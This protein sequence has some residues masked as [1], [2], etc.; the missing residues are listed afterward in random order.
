[1]AKLWIRVQL[2]PDGKIGP[3]KIALLEA[4]DR[5]GSISAAARDLGMSYRRAWLL[6]DETN[7]LFRDKV[8]EA[9]MGGAQG[10][11][12]ALS[13][14]GRKLVEQYRAIERDANRAVEARLAS[15]EAARADEPV[16]A[17]S[18]NRSA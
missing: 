13:A 15:L 16:T 9:S 2:T 10:G 1:M 6:V 12:A 17:G 14:F 4:I 18:K 11:G 5:A 8:V 3:G 7:R